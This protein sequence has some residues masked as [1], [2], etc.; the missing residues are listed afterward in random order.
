[1][2][3]G[4]IGEGAADAVLAEPS[5]QD[6]HVAE[7]V[8]HGRMGQSVALQFDDHAMANVCTRVDVIVVEAEPQVDGETLGH[9]VVDEGDAVE[10]VLHMRMQL[11]DGVP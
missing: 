6:T 4:G 7:D 10:E 1:M 3:Q 8:L 11:V 2:P 9:A 5:R